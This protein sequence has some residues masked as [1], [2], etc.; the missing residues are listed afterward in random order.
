MNKKVCFRLSILGWGILYLLSIDVSVQAKENMVFDEYYEQFHKNANFEQ[1]EED[2]YSIDQQY[3]KK[4][5]IDFMT[6]FQYVLNG[7]IEE[8]IHISLESCYENLTY[9]IRVNKELIVKII[10]LMI[11]AAIFN[12]YSSM[13]KFSFVGE[14]G[15][16]I[17]YLM[18]A[19]ALMQSFLLVYDIAE[20]TIYYLTDV[21]KCLLPAFQ[22]SLVLCS[23]LTTSQMV[24]S[25]FVWMLS[26]IEKLLLTLV[27]PF[28]R[29]YFLI[30]I[31]NQINGKDRFS[32]LAGLMKQTLQFILKSI[33]TGIIGLNLMKSILIPVYE[34]T[35]YN[36]LQKGISMLPGGSTLSG[37]STILLGA[38]VLIKNSVGITVVLIM[39]LLGSIPLLKMASFYLCYRL[40]LSFMQPISDQRILTGLQGAAESTELL[41]RS[42]AMTIVLSVLSIAI[43]IVTTNVRLYAGS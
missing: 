11:V 18:I 7:E 43:V 19:V 38:G 16:Y 36:A 32:K 22:M 40:I 29:V 27:L 25:M 14:Q 33:T 21:G 41:I 3:N 28:I 12:N 42:T 20:E 30:V 39:L 2:L 1:I 37:L 26:I 6:I 17:T 10:L 34:N 15:F 35:K 24:N 5:A 23:G 4:N 31:L 13:I 9:E 8:A